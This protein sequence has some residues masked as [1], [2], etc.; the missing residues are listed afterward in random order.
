MKWFSAI[1]QSTQ[2]RQLTSTQKDLIYLLRDLKIARVSAGIVVIIFLLRREVFLAFA[3]CMLPGVA[4]C[5]KRLVRPHSASRLFSVWNM[6]AV[7]GKSLSEVETPSLVL[8]LSKFHA[9]CE[10]MDTAIGAL[11]LKLRP[12]AKCHK[13]QELSLIQ[14]ALP[15]TSG[16]CVAKVSEA[17]AIVEKSDGAVKD[18][19]LTNQIVTQSKIDRLITSV[20]NRGITL[21]VCVDNKDNV[22]LLN[23]RVAALADGKKLEVY[24]EVDVGQN[25]CGVQPGDACGALAEHIMQHCP[26]LS[27]KGLQ[28]Y[29]GWNQHIKDVPTRTQK[30]QEVVDKV[31]MSLMSILDRQLFTLEQ[32]QNDRLLCIT[33]GGSGTWTLEGTLKFKTLDVPYGFTELQPGSYSVMDVEYSSTEACDKKGHYDN[34]LFVQT[35]V[36]SD[37]STHPQWV[38]VDAGDKAIHPGNASI[39]V[40]G[41]PDLTFRRGGDEHGILE[42][43]KAVLNQL[44]IGTILKLIPGHCDP[45]INFY[46]E[47]VGFRADT[48]KEVVEKVISIDGRGPGR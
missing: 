27:I 18:I 11:G 26:H 33:G 12:H 44:T 32:L 30:T 39:K 38:V 22:D 42:G 7:V 14:C 20:L 41:Y 3:L 23:E 31:E 45:T 34:A 5:L 6:D 8:D 40:Y 17:L 9:N 1:A 46:E 47:F 19:L 21:G 43:P 37:S 36:T 4:F 16:I 10:R 35:T 13:S 24:I 25:R 28:C 29:S 2:D 48:G 15:N